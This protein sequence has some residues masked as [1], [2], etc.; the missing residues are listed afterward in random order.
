M[1]ALRTQVTGDPGPERA[2]DTPSLLASQN[3]A[4]AN[5]AESIVVSSVR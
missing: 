1:A 5:G 3:K 2:T 4:K